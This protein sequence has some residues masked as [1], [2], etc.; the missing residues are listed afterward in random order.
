MTL[1]RWAL[2]V[3][4][5]VL[6]GSACG[7][8]ADGAADAAID[9]FP[10]APHTPYPAVPDQGGPRLAHPQLITVTFA[11]DPRAATFEA[12]AQWIVTS[13]WLG[14]VGTEYGVGPGGVAGVAHRPETPPPTLTSADIESYLASGITD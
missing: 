9:A 11:N 5:V 3:V 8:G 1:V 6:I 12:F 14:A 13:H 2:A 10:T 7:S 4:V